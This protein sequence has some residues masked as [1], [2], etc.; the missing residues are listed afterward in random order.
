MD[1]SKNKIFWPIIMGLAGLKLIIHFVTNSITDFGLHRDEYLYI[2]DSDHLD[3]GYMEGPPFIA[4]IGKIARLFFGDTLFAVRFYPALIGA[5]TIVLLGILIRDLG[6][7]RNAQ[8]IGCSAFLLSPA[9]LGS[10]NLF[11]PVSFNQFFWFLIAFILVRIVTTPIYKSEYARYWYAFGVVCGVAILTKYSVIFFIL[12]LFVGL[13]FSSH[14]KK[15]FASKHL[16]ISMV[17]ALLIVSPNIWWQYSHDFPILKHMEALS[18]TQLVNVSTIDFIIP[19]FL[20]HFGSSFIWVVGLGFVLFHPMM[21]K[22]QFLGFAY[23]AVMLI[24]WILNGKDYYPFG[25]YAMLFALGAIAWELV[26]GRKAWIL[27]PLILLINFSLFPLALPILKSD[28]MASYSQAFQK[29]GI[30]SPFRWEDDTVRN[31]RQDYADMLGWDEIPIKVASV[32]HN[33]SD[34]EKSR[35]II[36][37]GHYGQAGVMNFYRKKYDLPETYSFNASFVNWI[38]ENLDFDIQIQ[39]DD[40][41]QG[42]SQYFNSVILMDSIEHP[43]ARDPGYIY[44]KSQ[45]KMDLA[46][47]W[48]EIVNQR[49]KDS[50]YK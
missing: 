31:L 13:L 26:L 5:V 9:F 48:N 12:S 23:L 47:V 20:N 42:A 7:K 36:Y 16:Y 43:L 49:K 8:L 24:I 45:P 22:Y 11:Q 4:I 18:S 33:L 21:K 1:Y 19:Q 32:Y 10:N 37:A 40:R 28:K 17:L 27:A 35:C 14:R 44:I 15:V 3:W 50:G 29:K 46:P 38:P 41:K 34:D 2:S 6:G 39:V 25:S 30:T